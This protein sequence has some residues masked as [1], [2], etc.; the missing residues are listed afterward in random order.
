[1]DGVNSLSPPA[2]VCGFPGCGGLLEKTLETK[3]PPD[4]LLTK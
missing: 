4:F 3:I 1:M 2:L